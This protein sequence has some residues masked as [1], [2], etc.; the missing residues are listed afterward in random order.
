MAWHE[1]TD[2]IQMYPHADMS[3]KER[4]L[5]RLAPPKPSGPDEASGYFHSKYGILM[6][7]SQFRPIVAYQ[8]CPLEDRSTAPIGVAFS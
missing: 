6:D 1:S 8:R 2:A 5:A 4:A 7:A 3:I